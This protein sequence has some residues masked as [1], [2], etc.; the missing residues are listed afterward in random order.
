MK[1]DT[2]LH[3]LIVGFL[4]LGATILLFYI[5]A[6]SAEP[7]VTKIKIIGL[8]RISEESIKKRLSQKIMEPLS[9]D[10]ISRDIKEL[11]KLGYFEDI[12][13]EV[14]PEEGGL[15]LLYIF[16]EHPTIVRVAFY[17][18]KEFKDEKLQDQITISVGAIANRHLIMSNVKALK[19]FYEAKGY[20]L[21]EVIPLLYRISDTEAS[22]TFYIKEGP[23]VKI[24]KIT[25]EG[26][27][28]L[29]EKDIKDVMETSE[30]GFF[31]F[32]TGKGYYEK[33]KL[34]KDLESIKNLYYNHGYLNVKVYEPKI[35]LSKDKRHLFIKIRIDEGP[36]YRI[37]LIELEGVSSSEKKTLKRFIKMKEGEVFSKKALTTSIRAIVEY[38]SEHGYAVATV[39]PQIIP[40]NKALLVDVVLKIDKGDIYRIGRI[41]I[42]GNTKTKDKV[43]RREI[44]I[45]EGDLYNSKLLKRSYE[46]IY[47]LNYFD[48]VEFKPKPNPEKKTVDIEV[49]VKEKP[50]GFFSIG[51]G[52]S[53]VDQWVGMIE[54]TETNFLGSG[55]QVKLSGQFSGKATYYELNYRDPWFMD[56]EISMSLSLYRTQRDYTLY[57]KRAWG[58][59]VGFGKKFSEYWS[60][61]MRYD[62]ER[63]TI[64]DVS[65]NAS[66][67]VKEQEGTTE[68]SSISPSLIYDSRDFFLD[69]S[70]G[71]R[72]GFY[73]T[74]A[75]LGGD[76]KFIKAL[77]DV[78]KYFP[79][80]SKTVFSARARVGYAS[81]LWGEKLPLY[82]RFYVGGLY[83]VRGLG[84]GEAGPI[85]ISGEP[86]G[87]TRELIFNFEYK[88]PLI[89]EIRFKGVLFFDVGRAYDTDEKFGS[90]LRY[91]AG[92]GIRWISPVGPLRFEYGWNLDRRP[93]ERSGK[94]EFAIGGF[95]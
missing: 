95:F 10:K 64:F 77:I 68:T 60:V 26:N 31:S 62:Y 73:L 91:T 69:P 23:K 32:L 27:S 9:I 61:G 49:K 20:Y 47:N 87:G 71:S 81:G 3:R 54:L 70:R 29:E 75:G 52:Y 90:D 15:V 30:Y 14:E 45:D 22:L 35:T 34:Q 63:A 12:R 28:A 43:I 5:N 44:R 51:G 93:G 33:E 50:T 55:K 66:Q 65:Q 18:N 79:V 88:F 1:E 8:R 25:I 24:E 89:E 94:F 17:G 11:Y 4:I 92:V 85:D 78:A 82:E 39:D 72:L 59:G 76:N 19:K 67:T 13:V 38:Y 41:E 57:T 83:T 80:T 7:L 21:A 58:A 2:I 84:F 36:Q 53:S 37:R 42:V 46:R 16:K 48:S 74:L 86:I 56:K 6:A 40:D